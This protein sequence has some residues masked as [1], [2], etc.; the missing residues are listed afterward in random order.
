MEPEIIIDVMNRKWVI[1]LVEPDEE[2]YRAYAYWDGGIFDP[3]P[4]LKDERFLDFLRVQ[5]AHQHKFI[6]SA[7]GYTESLAIENIKRY[8]KASG[9][10]WA[11]AALRFPSFA[12]TT[13]GN[14]R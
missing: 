7:V 8:V 5:A 12:F 4:D 2:G 3:E 10:D 11:S 1:G 9:H 13:Y 6:L 14:W